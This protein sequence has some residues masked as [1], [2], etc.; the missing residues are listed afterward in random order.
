[1]LFV[2]YYGNYVSCRH[3]L[4]VISFT[5]SML[6]EFSF[7]INTFLVKIQVE[8][9]GYFSGG[10]LLRLRAVGGVECYPSI[11]DKKCREENPDIPNSEKLF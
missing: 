11:Y 1:M 10:Y 4:S 8:K 9:V 2:H 7:T 3:T 6:F 5:A